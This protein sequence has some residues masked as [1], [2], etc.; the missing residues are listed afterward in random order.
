M[1]TENS[2]NGDSDYQTTSKIVLLGTGTPIADPTRA[3]PSVAIVVDGT[4][5]LID[6]GPGVVRQA[7]AAYQAGIEALEVK[8]L[9]LAFLT[10]LHSDHAVGYPDLILTPWVLR[11]EEPL[12]VYG[13]VGTR[14]M[15]EHI[16]EAYRED[17]NERLNGLEPI[18]D[19][20]F[21]VNVHEIEPGIIYRDSNVVVEAFPA[22]HGS[23]QAFGFKF[24]A[25]D[26][27]IVISGDTAPSESLVEEYRGCDVLLHEVYSL[28]GFEARPANWRRYHS[29]VHTSSRELA[30]IASRVRPGLLTLYHQLFWAASE[31]GILAEIQE[32]YDG[33][34]VSGKDLEVY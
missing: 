23:L 32:R 21:L 5:Y 31:E 20:G 15:T 8:R 4:P 11:R 3:G 16:L 9:K 19:I 7:A 12:E 13:P 17:I 28:E 6:F 18:N 2:V 1:D 33:R 10:H 27:K 26:R 25:P 24:H 29:S 14:A 22:S 30:Q 34:V